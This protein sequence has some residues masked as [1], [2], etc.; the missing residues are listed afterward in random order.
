MYANLYSY[1]ILEDSLFLLFLIKKFI[2]ASMDWKILTSK[3]VK[4][5]N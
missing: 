4:M 3:L 5:N 2:S 1:L